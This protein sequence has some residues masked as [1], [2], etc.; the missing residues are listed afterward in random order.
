MGKS[1]LLR[2]FRA[3]PDRLEVECAELAESFRALDAEAQERLACEMV[4]RAVAEQ[5]PPLELPFDSAALD[6]LVEEL[7]ASEDERAFRRARA[8]SAEQF[9]RRDSYEDALYEAVHARRLV[10]AAVQEAREALR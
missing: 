2:T 8:A 4:Q 7:D 1:R 6:T 3:V 10:P 5:D 9:L